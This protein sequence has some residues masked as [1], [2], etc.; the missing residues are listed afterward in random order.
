MAGEN[1]TDGGS[2]FSS[3][4]MG[5]EAAIDPVVRPSAQLG[6][7]GA[8][9]KWLVIFQIRVRVKTNTIMNGIRDYL[10][11]DEKKSLSSFSVMNRMVAGRKGDFQDSPDNDGSRQKEDCHL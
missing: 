11:K 9:R 1:E 5:V 7:C 6:A 10:S 2:R 8:R 3:R 4:S